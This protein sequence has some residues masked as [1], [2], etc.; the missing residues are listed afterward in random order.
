MME[1]LNDIVNNIMPYFQ[2]LCGKN[3][4]KVLQNPNT[5]KNLKF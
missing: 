5:L 4:D 3:A 1:S 2:N